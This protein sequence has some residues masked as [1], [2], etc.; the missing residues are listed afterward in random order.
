V[1]LVGRLGGRPGVAPVP[2]WTFG[3]PLHQGLAFLLRR[4]VWKVF[5][6]RRSR[7]RLITPW[8]YGTRAELVLSSDMGRCVW[9]GGCFEPNEMYLLSRLLKTGNTFI[10]VGANIGLYTLTAARLVGPRG[11]VL[12]FEPSPRE[13]E[14]LDRNVIR[15]SLTQVSV[16]SRAIGDVENAHVTLHLADEQHGGQNTLGAVVYENARVVENA[17]VQMTTLDHAVVEAGFDTVDVVKIDVEGA[18]FLVLSGAHDTLSTI[19]PVLMMELQD[20][21]LIAQGSGAREVVSL[22]SG[23][24]YGLYSYASRDEPHLL[25]PFDA[26]E[27]RVA[28]DVVAVPVEK[29][30]LVVTA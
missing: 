26:S 21:S 25:Q 2:E 29:Q 27:A 10:D 16:D 9:V 18:E 23:F 3:Q 30:R 11:R 28:Q 6:Q 14:L 4:A 12:A 17:I 20:D 22:L 5:R 15:N 13:R 1:N 24:D 8:L 19:R 7:Y